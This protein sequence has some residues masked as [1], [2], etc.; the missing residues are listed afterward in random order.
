[1]NYTALA[2]RIHL[3]LLEEMTGVLV[4]VNRPNT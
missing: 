4:R 3:A 1:M 2:Q